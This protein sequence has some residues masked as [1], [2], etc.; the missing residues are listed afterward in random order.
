LVL[1]LFT[2]YI[3]GVAK[4]KKIIPAPKRLKRKSLLQEF[5]RDFSV[6]VVH[7]WELCSKMDETIL[8][9][10]T[11]S[12]KTSLGAV[13]LEQPQRNKQ[14]VDEIIQDGRCV[15][16]DTTART[17]GIAYNFKASKNINSNV[18]NK[19]KPNKKGLFFPWNTD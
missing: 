5:T 8:K 16:V 15:T 1:V 17:L 14:R 10:G 6:L 12:S 9:P 18:I 4:F 19:F 7:G 3:Q 11:R 13:D 2:F